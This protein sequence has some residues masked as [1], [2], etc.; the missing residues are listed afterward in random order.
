MELIDVV[1]KLVAQ[2]MQ[3]SG[4]TD[5]VVGRVTGVGPLSITEQDVRDPIPAVALRL[6]SAVVE[7][8]FPVLSHRHEVVHSHSIH[9]TYSGGG[10]CGEGGT[11]SE[12][13]GGAACYENG[14]KLPVKDGYILMNRGLEVGDQVLMLRVMGGQNYIV[15]SRVYESVSE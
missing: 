10:S 15:L 9:D 3:A 11:C 6:T 8:R 5:L 4:L 12:E 13:L 2:T 14:V 1:Q 7:K